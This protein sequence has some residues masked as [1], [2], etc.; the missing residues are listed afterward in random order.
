MLSSLRNIQILRD[1]DDTELQEISSRIAH[2]LYRKG[3]VVIHQND[4]ASKV[5][6]LCSGLA[7]VQLSSPQGAEVAICEI[8]AGEVFGD[9]SAIDGQTRS[10]T[11]VAIN[12]SVIGLMSQQDF[13]NLVTH[14]PKVALRQMQQLTQQL[15]LMNNRITD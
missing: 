2:T 1:L 4:G 13:V 8:Q 5:M 14:N 12:E 3:D 15:R 11:V 7:K 10:A 6:L 9:W